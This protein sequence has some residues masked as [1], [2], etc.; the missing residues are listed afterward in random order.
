MM[1]RSR[2][3]LAL[4][5]TLA[6]TACSGLQLDDVASD[7]P[8]FDFQATFEGHM[9]ASGWFADRFGKPRRHFCGD[10]IGTMEGD[11]LSLDETLFYTDGV[12]EKRVWR[13]SVSDEG[14]FRATSDSLQGDAVGQIE[15]NGL[16]MRYTMTIGM[17]G[18]EEGVF[19]FNDFMLLQP[20]G[21][22]HNITHVL[23][24]GVRLGAVSTQYA[25][26]DGS[27]TCA[28]RESDDASS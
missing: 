24:W 27:Q 19:D 25:R 22:V 8:A 15:G 23:K 20:D 17:P 11:V 10:F 9:R 26:H 12:V 18:G 28:A 16:Q 6:L 7:T 1:S 4:G 5:A 13:V 21:S 3:V 14:E 2:H